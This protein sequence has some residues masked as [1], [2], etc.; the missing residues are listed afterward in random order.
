VRR[1]AVL[2]TAIGLA[3]ALTGGGADSSSAQAAVRD[4]F[5]RTVDTGSSRFTLSLAIPESEAAPR[6]DYKIDGLMDYVR[7]R[8]RISFGSNSELLIDGN[9]TYMQTTL[10]WRHDTV[11]VGSDTSGQESD[12]FDLQ[13][14]AMNNPLSLLKFLTE[15]G[16]DLRN[17]GTEQV[18][19][20]ETTHYEG[21]L[22]LQ[23]VVENAPPQERANLK[24]TLDF[25]GQFEPTS[26]PFGLW[27]DRDG[28]ARRLRI[29]Q[30]GGSSIV[31]EYYE[32]GAPVSIT[33]PPMDTMITF[34][35]LFK[36]V[37]NHQTDSNCKDGESNTVGSSYN[38]QMILPENTETG[39]VGANA[40]ELVPSSSAVYSVCSTIGGG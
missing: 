30:K 36:E 18:R 10:P 11:W 26:V 40:G 12:P 8:G 15:V 25:I 23:D 39:S 38:D 31:I 7:H 33:R 20:A 27:V 32:F 21:T 14:R 37:E 22:N 3:I 5:V 13:E 29:D 34:E 6:G 17:V 35:E 24:D 4:A 2:A 9:M 19:G 1:A 16:S 28:V